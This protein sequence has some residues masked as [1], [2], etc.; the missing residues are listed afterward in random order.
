MTNTPKNPTPPLRTAFGPSPSCSTPNETRHHYH[1]SW[2]RTRTP[3]GSEGSMTK[4]EFKD[5]CDINGIMARYQR[6]GA[7]SHFAKWAPTY[8]EFS[9]CD[10]Q[11]AQN[12]VIRANQMFAELPSS[13]RD[14]THT[15]EGFL[16]FVQDPAN[17][18]KLVELGLVPAPP[19]IERPPEAT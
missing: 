6:T 15:P 2:K 9:P 5:E 14:L 8:G 18:A 7:I 17:A 13:I 12:T 4:Q 11:S 16:A 19:V 1:L 10:L 3:I